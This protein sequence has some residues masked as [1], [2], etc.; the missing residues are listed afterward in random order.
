MSAASVTGAGP[1]CARLYFQE[2]LVSLLSAE[3]L[4]WSEIE[5]PVILPFVPGCQ[6]KLFPGRESGGMNVSARSSHVQS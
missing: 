5:R 1:S 4:L 2:S 6:E 3:W